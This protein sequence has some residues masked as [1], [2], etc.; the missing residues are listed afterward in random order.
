MKDLKIPIGWLIP[1]I[2]FVILLGWF[3][4]RSGWNLTEV[5]TGIAKLAPPTPSVILQPTPTVQ[6]VVQQPTNTK[7][8]PVLSTPATASGGLFLCGEPAFN[9]NLTTRDPL[10][11]RPAG[12]L[13]GWISSDPSTVILPNGTT[14]VFET[15]YVLIVEDLPSVQV[16]GVQRQA[17][18]ANTWGCWYSADLSS[19][20]A[21]DAKTDFCKKKAGGNVAVMYKVSSS[22]FEEIATT[23]TISCP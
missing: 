15:Q 9:G 14:K 16:R 11:L 7:P 1:I 12:Y 5:D 19:F 2:G 21:E 18:K 13:S 20:I 23:A 17:G 4:G 6:Q 3:L 8:V 10:F 22:G